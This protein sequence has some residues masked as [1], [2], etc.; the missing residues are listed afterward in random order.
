MELD[1]TGVLESQ[2]SWHWE[3]NLR[4]R[5]NDLSDAE[6]LWEPVPGS[7][8][9]RPAGQ[10]RSRRPA[11]TGATV[12][13]HDWPDP[14]PSPVTTIAWRINHIQ[15]G[16]FGERNNRYFGGP[17]VSYA[18][19]DY[20]LSA[21]E[22]LGRLDEGYARW[23]AGIRGLDLAGLTQN[24]REP[25]FESDS[26]ASLVQHINRELIHHGAEICLLRDLY[27]RR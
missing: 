5:W 11:G 6:Y 19:Y 24:C 27:L 25:G 15:V 10:A 14:E 23:I 1:W 3:N 9:I 2:L 12:M 26:M 22:A 20:P 17:P 8:S 16:V 13:D 21:A 7:W 18:D 4:P